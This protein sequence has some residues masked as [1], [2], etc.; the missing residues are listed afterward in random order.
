MA[1]HNDLRGT[2]EVLRNARMCCAQ[3]RVGRRRI[4]RSLPPQLVWL[5]SDA[6]G[7]GG[8]TM[9]SIRRHVNRWDRREAFRRKV[10]AD[11]QSA[12]KPGPKPVLRGDAELP[13]K[14]I[15]VTAAVVVPKT[16][17]RSFIV[18]PDGKTLGPLC[19]RP[20]GIGQRV[21]PISNRSACVE[22]CGHVHRPG[23]GGSALGSA[24]RK[25]RAADLAIGGPDG[26]TP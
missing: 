23:Y 18:P 26:N 24:A 7:Y 20:R 12:A 10:M 19:R 4:R 3:A 14:R 25:D 13:G 9:T 2:A 5:L 21:S 22:G 11:K 8:V 16:P 17:R 1:P 15:R 6:D